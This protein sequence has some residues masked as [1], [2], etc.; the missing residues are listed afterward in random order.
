MGPH[1]RDLVATTL[2]MARLAQYA[3]DSTDPRDLDR[4]NPGRIVNS[5]WDRYGHQVTEAL[6]SLWTEYFSQVWRCDLAP[7][8]SYSRFHWR[9]AELKPHVDRPSCEY[10]CTVM[11]YGDPWPIY[12]AGEEYLLEPGD[13]ITYKGAE[14]EHWRQPF[15]GEG[16]LIATFH[17]VDRNGPYKDSIYDGR[18]GLGMP[19]VK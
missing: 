11:L 16:Y 1:S 9:G 8:Y 15:E 7:T 18:V 5:C 19:P 12:M 17:W 14:V 3:T 4:Y 13:A 6:L 2:D 10:S